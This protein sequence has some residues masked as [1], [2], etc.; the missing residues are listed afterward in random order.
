MNFRSDNVAA[1]AP[2][3]MAAVA[4]ANV[5][6]EGAYGAD[7]ITQRLSGLF[8]ALFG[9]EVAVF[10]TVTGT[11]ANALALAALTPS[12]GAIYCHRD[13]HI[14]KEECGAPEFFTGGAKLIALPGA[15]AKIDPDALQEALARGGR[16]DVHYAQPATLSVTQQTEEGAV[17]RPE[18]I[19]GLAALARRHGLAV[20]MDGARFAN[21]VAALGCAPAE[22]T[23]RAGVDVLSFGATKNGAF[24]AEAIVLFRP[25]LA[26]ALAYQ[27]KRAGQLLSKMRFVAAQLE[28]YLAG[29]LWLKLAA[30]AN[31]MAR[32]LADGLS[33]LPGVHLSDAVEGNEVFVT[34]P[35]TVIAG[36]EAAGAG[37]YRWPESDRLSRTI[38]L[39]AG[40]DTKESEVEAFLAHARRLAQQAP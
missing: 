31:A 39:V 25:E 28:A 10:P 38:R 12:Y 7:E 24:A 21:A 2:P 33:T 1:V 11:A 26:Q 19:R 13:A 14:N 18:E 16:G 30:R 34:L 17:Y 22:I 27:H 40:H 29:G 32:R 9:T 36:L 23:W 8:G 35:E 3:I 4:A 5:R 20:H 15:R 6:S 37:F